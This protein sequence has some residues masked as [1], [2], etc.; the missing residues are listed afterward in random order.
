M[1]FISLFSKTANYKRFSY[2]P[3]YY[4]AKA[5]E[6]KEREE[7]IRLEIAR[8][9]GEMTASDTTYRGRISGSFHAARKR[10]RQ[11]SGDTSATMLRLGV[12]LFLALF[13]IAFFTWGKVVVY[14]LLLFI[15]LYFYLRFK[16]GGK[17]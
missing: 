13:L 5:E 17:A 12:L 10:S 8:E 11:G 6:R 1:K 14:S 16:K 7:R 9:K 15:P 2:E 3:R 4:D